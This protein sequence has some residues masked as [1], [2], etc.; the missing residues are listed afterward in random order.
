MSQICKFFG[1]V[2][3]IYYDDH[4]PPHFHA[5]YGEYEVLINIET[6]SIFSGYLPSRALG[7]V[8]EWASLHHIELKKIWQ[9]AINHQQLDKIE[10]LK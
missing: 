10:P 6:L 8:V 2:I 5:R 3:Y 1:I 4:H 9:Q 7:L